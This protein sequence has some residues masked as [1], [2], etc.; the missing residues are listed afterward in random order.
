MRQQFP[1]TQIWAFGLRA[2]G[3]AKPDSD[4]DICVVVDSLEPTVK[5]ASSHI[6][7]EISFHRERCITTV[8]FPAINL[9]K[10][11]VP[12]VLWYKPSG[13]RA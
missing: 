5:K 4:L 13:V 12:S 9:T 2:R 10:V 1:D 8:K 3:D 11:L 7:W 6:A